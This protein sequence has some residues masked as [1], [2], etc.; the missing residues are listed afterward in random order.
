MTTTMISIVA[1]IGLLGWNSLT[2]FASTLATT[3][4]F[5]FKRYA[6]SDPY[7]GRFN[8]VGFIFA[9][10]G[11]VAMFLATIVISLM[12]VELS[13]II[14]GKRFGEKITNLKQYKK[15]TYF[16]IVAFAIV[17]GL[18]ALIARVAKLPT[19]YPLTFIPFQ[20]I[21]IVTYTVGAYRFSSILNS[22]SRKLSQK[23]TVSN[24]SPKTLKTSSKASIDSSLD[25]VDDETLKTVNTKI[26]S[27]SK[28]ES[29]PI[30]RIIVA[31]RD[32]TIYIVLLLLISL[33]SGVTQSVVDIK[34]STKGINDGV[35]NSLP[36]D[37]LWGAYKVAYFVQVSAF[38]FSLVVITQYLRS[39]ARRK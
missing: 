29:D 34:H 30:K 26:R 2:L 11:I 39:N 19:I 13:E 3:E 10:V 9:S 15:F 18:S 1:G 20:V 12:W 16:F 7:R 31:V 27:N 17:G 8:G 35:Q 37:K 36:P 38:S 28:S 22:N 4:N 32:T 21:M 24:S 5:V 33:V 25:L 6:K 23:V 14:G